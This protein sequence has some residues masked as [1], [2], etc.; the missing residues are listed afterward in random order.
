MKLSLGKITHKSEALTNLEIKF[1]SKI[2]KF[3]E[4]NIS[5]NNKNDFEYKNVLN[6]FRPLISEQK[7]N[8]EPKL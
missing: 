2:Q 7:N 8:R 6:L 4:N 5:I 3:S 1:H